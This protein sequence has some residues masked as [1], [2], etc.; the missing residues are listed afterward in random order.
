MAQ[1]STLALY[2]VVRR[3]S[4]PI[5]EKPTGFRRGHLVV[6]ASSLRVVLE[7]RTV[8]LGRHLSGKSARL[9]A[10]GTTTSLRSPLIPNVPG[11]YS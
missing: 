10:K 6:D 5:S 9:T 4:R 3:R 7:S 8:T 1:V 11:C 2:R